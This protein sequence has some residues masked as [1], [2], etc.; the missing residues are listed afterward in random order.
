VKQADELLFKY[1]AR[2]REGARA[3]DTRGGSW[4]ASVQWNDIERRRV[5]GWAEPRPVMG[6]ILK[7][8][9]ASG[10]VGV[11]VFTGVD[12]CRDPPDMFFGAVEF[13]GY[14]DELSTRSEH[15]AS[16]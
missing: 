15:E 10:R 3:F 4:G 9:M 12:L 5:H 11:F 14:D 8:P 6:D 13:I 1:K 2:P 16:Q 7:S